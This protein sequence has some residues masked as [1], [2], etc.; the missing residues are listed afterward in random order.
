MIL[1]NQK[2]ID[3]LEVCEDRNVAYL[4]PKILH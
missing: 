4:F 2:N 1:I 3:R